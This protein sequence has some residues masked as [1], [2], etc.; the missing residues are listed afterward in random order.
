MRCPDQPILLSLL[1]SPRLR[2]ANARLLTAFQSGARGWHI[3]R[4]NL[5]QRPVPPYGLSPQRRPARIQPGA[6]TE[7]VDWFDRADALVVASP[8][9]FYGFPAHAKAMIDRCHPLYHNPYWRR[10]PKRPAYFISTCAASR[11]REF[12]IIVREAK[13]FF[14]TIGFQYAGDLLVPGM[15]ACDA[16]VRLERSLSRARAL[17]RRLNRVAACRESRH[18]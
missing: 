13:A 6:M 3:Q 8:V 17:G 9:Y 16:A 18:E 12:E 15:D 4:F 2:G 11:R 5:S 14:N 7:L 10:R 1:A